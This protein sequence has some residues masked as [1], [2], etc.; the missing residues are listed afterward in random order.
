MISD[1]G[2][3]VK[4]P[5][6]PKRFVEQPLPDPCTKN[7]LLYVAAEHVRN[8]NPCR[9]PRNEISLGAATNLDA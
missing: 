4:S 5:I 7:K 1:G 2:V 9:D 6:L 3:P 8:G